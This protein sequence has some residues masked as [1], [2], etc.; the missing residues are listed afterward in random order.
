M[1]NIML[2]K[3]RLQVKKHMNAINAKVFQTVVEIGLSSSERL[4]FD[5]SLAVNE[6]E[7]SELSDFPLIK[8]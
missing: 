8:C 5:N 6:A 1:Q 4:Q 3:D 7:N 2:R